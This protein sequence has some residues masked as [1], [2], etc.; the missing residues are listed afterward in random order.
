MAEKFSTT[1]ENT[2]KLEGE[3][4]ALAHNELLL[5]FAKAFS[6]Q[7]LLKDFFRPYPRTEETTSAR[8]RGYLI[9]RAE[10]LENDSVAI[11]IT[12]GASEQDPPYL[13]SEVIKLGYSW[14]LD[15]DKQKVK[16][17]TIQYSREVGLSEH[18]QLDLADRGRGFGMKESEWTFTND[19]IAV[20]RIEKFIK[21]VKAVNSS[22]EVIQRRGRV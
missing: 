9:E 8:W 11:V 12:K 15:Q 1:S 16:K 22:S 4:L 2:P 19:A 7:K 10:S 18:A 21:K 6:R 17:F 20:R 5:Q 3:T 14:D 13:H